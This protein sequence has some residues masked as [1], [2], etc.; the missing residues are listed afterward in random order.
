MREILNRRA[1]GEQELLDG[2][3]EVDQASIY[4]HTHSYYLHGKYEYDRFPNDFA[5]WI[6]ESVRDRLLSE[7]LAIISPFQFDNLEALREEF[8]T[9]IDDHLGHLGFSPRSLSGEPFEF[10]RAQIVSFSTGIEVRTR[11]ELLDAI[12]TA[13]T[14]VL[15]YHFFED[16]FRRGARIG[17]LVNW[18]ADELGDESLAESLARLN[19]YRLHIERLRSELLAI[20]GREA[21]GS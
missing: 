21:G 4:Y 12:R 14:E 5:A 18:V 8:V 3:E 13:S 10:F 15:F 9:T 6:S 19:P 7:R 20:L 16:V 1:N 17:S 2:V 11:E